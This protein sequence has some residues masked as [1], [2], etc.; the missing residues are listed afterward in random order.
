MI[1]KDTNNTD[2]PDPGEMIIKGGG[3]IN[4]K[5]HR[6][7]VESVRVS[8]FAYSRYVEDYVADSATPDTIVNYLPFDKEGSI[9][10]IKDSEYRVDYD[11]TTPA[12]TQ[13]DDYFDIA[14]EPRA[15][16]TG[17]FIDSDPDVHVG[18]MVVKTD[19]FDLNA[20]SYMTVDGVDPL[21][22]SPDGKRRF[23]DLIH[24][25]GGFRFEKDYND[26]VINDVTGVVEFTDVDGV[27]KRGNN[28]IVKFENDKTTINRK[29]FDWGAKL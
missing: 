10:R 23:T 22:Q 15:V 14:L 16:E 3:I 1:V 8:K 19:N 9:F 18:M 6:S 20:S 25:H 7:N 4:N 29:V 13:T 11:D 2:V 5:L 24:S 27:I 12:I 21:G 17:N 26:S 28:E